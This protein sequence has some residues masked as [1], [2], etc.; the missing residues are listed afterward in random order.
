LIS[1]RRWARTGAPPSAGPSRIQLGRSGRVNLDWSYLHP[2]G[3]PQRFD[4]RVTNAGLVSIR[5]L[6]SRA[7]PTW[8]IRRFAALDIRMIPEARSVAVEHSDRAERA[9]ESASR[10]PSR[11]PTPLPDA[12]PEESRQEASDRPRSASRSQRALHRQS[13]VRVYRITLPQE[14]FDRAVNRVTLE[15]TESRRARGSKGRWRVS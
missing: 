11:Y 3:L 4:R 8:S 1:R 9:F 10:S 13:P 14:L 7:G 2:E 5:A 12:G 6:V 15:V